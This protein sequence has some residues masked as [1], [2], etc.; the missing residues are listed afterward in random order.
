M[1]KKFVATTDRAEAEKECPWA[2]VI[3]EVEGGFRCFRYVSD[4]EEWRSQT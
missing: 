2:A 4:Y 3:I 1:D